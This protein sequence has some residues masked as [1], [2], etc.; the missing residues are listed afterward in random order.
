MKKQNWL[1]MG[2]IAITLIYGCASEENLSSKAN[3]TEIKP[4]QGSS[5]QVYQLLLAEAYYYNHQDE[6]AADNFLAVAATTK[7]SYIAER[8]IDLAIKAKKYDQALIAALR[9]K[10]FDSKSTDLGQYLVLLYQEKGL[11]SEAAKEM[12]EL[13]KSLNKL[14]KPGLGIAVA[15]LDQSDSAI[16]SYEIMKLYSSKYGETQESL[17]FEAL[18]AF[19]SKNYESVLTVTDSLEGI[20][21][22]ALVE[23]ELLQKVLY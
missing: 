11:L 9:W 4:L 22:K 6:L 19:R 5:E 23:K 2:V 16:K 7:D 15:L 10:T 13:V 17:Y 8:S 21:K 3:Q 20:D 14:S 1:Y 12:G 18:F